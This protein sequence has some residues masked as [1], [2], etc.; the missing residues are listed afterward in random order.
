MS[1]EIKRLQE[2][3]GLNEIKINN[4][5]PI[6]D[7]DEVEILVNIYYDGEEAIPEYELENYGYELPN[8]DDEYPDVELYIPKYTEGTYFDG[9][10]ESNEGSNTRIDTKYLR[11][12]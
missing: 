2:L 4:P 1:K 8:N 11:K 3:A 10:F 9:S 5:S 12:I 7:G 6:K